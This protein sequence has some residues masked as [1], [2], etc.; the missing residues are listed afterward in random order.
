M[1]DPVKGHHESAVL[2]VVQRMG[3]GGEPLGQ[4]CGGLQTGCWFRPLYHRTVWW[5]YA[6]TQVHLHRQLRWWDL[7]YCKLNILRT[8]C[9]TS[10]L[11]ILWKWRKA[12]YRYMIS[13]F[14]N[15]HGHFF[16][17]QFKMHS[18]YSKMK[19]KNRVNSACI[20]HFSD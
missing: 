16:S 7:I 19:K 9:C 5:L 13:I 8:F 15:L 12:S 2:G 1:P 10:V 17:K 6:T 11:Q 20:F 18:S 14:V 3:E 4:S